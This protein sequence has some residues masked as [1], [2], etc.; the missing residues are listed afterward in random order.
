MIAKNYKI[1][2]FS[3]NL[4]FMG[5]NRNILLFWQSM[6]GWLPSLSSLNNVFKTF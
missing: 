5:S 6:H 1:K 4:K 2:S 3:H